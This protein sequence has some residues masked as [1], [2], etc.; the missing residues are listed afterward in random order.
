MGWIGAVVT[1]LAIAV[2]ALT[3]DDNALLRGSFTLMERLAWIVILPFNLLSLASGV[4]SAL[5]SQW[6]L[7][8]HYWVVT[9][10]VINCVTTAFL[11]GYE[12]EIRQLAHI[13]AHPVLTEQDLLALREPMN[14]VHATVALA[15][16]L[17]AT[18]LA[19]YKPAGLTRYGA[20]RAGRRR[21]SPMSAET[22]A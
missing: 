15:L 19:V 3:T 2:V 20:R 1:Y 11:L 13:A 16:L 12:L 18:V 14:V 4:T 21:P 22:P 10:L 8:R 7:L 9:K 5:M 17:I 6:G